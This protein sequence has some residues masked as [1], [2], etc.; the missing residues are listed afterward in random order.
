MSA[1][2]FKR[3]TVMQ[4]K[5]V[6]LILGLMRWGDR[7]CALQWPGPM[8]RWTSE[9]RQVRK[10]AAVVGFTCAVGCLA[11]FVSTQHAMARDWNQAYENDDTPWDKG[12]AAPP[13]VE[14]LE[15]HKVEGEILVPGCGSGHDVRLLA[16]QNGSEVTGL[17]IAPSALKKAA[18]FPKVGEERYAQGD[19]INLEEKYHGAFDWVFEHTCL[20]AIEPSQRQ[21]YVESLKLALKPGAFFLAIFFREV[22]NYTGDGPPHP[23]SA[24]EIDALF[25]KDFDVIE[26]FVPQQ[27]YPS[28]PVGSEDVRWMR[29]VADG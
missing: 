28:R 5:P 6:F 2:H 26:S 11:T 29:K 18:S 22:S 8:Q 10:E 19:F 9:T 14:F 7:V 4:K 12:Y 15:R 24:A 27:T 17:D 23:I 21:A 20:C 3:A 13:L 16:E 25:A 1:V